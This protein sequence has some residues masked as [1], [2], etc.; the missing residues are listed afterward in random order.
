MAPSMA[1]PDSG[2]IWSCPFVALLEI[3]QHDFPPV[4]LHTMGDRGMVKETVI[5]LILFYF[6]TDNALERVPEDFE[7]SEFL[8]ISP[9]LFFFGFSVCQR[10]NTVPKCEKATISNGTV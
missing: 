10:S 1:K 8:S 7:S 4:S 3:C 2:K 5:L 6:S 9:E